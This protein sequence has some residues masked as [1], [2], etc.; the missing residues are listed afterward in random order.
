MEHPDQQTRTK[1]DEIQ[2]L[3]LQLHHE[4]CRREQAQA[5]LAH[6]QQKSE[7]LRSA[8][9]A[10]D[11]YLKRIDGTTNGMLDC[12]RAWLDAKGGRP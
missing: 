8:G 11:E 9:D 7:R 3:R 2:G 5:V 4:R 10:M 6:E 12:R 1:D